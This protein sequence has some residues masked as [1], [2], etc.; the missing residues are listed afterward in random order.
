MAEKISAIT[1][2]SQEH[3]VH[4]VN[5]H[6]ICVAEKMS[7][8]S[9]RRTSRVEDIAYCLMGIFDINMSLLYGEGRKAF[10]RLQQEIVRVFYDM[11]IFAWDQP[12]NRTGSV[13]AS[14]PAGFSASGGIRLVREGAMITSLAQK[15]HNDLLTS[16]ATTNKGLQIDADVWKRSWAYS[17]ADCPMLSDDKW[18]WL[19]SC[20]KFQTAENGGPENCLCAVPLHRNFWATKGRLWVRAEEKLVFLYANAVLRNYRNLQRE[21][22]YINIWGKEKLASPG[23][24]HL[25]HTTVLY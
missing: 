12:D 25:K 1:G 23:L 8:A 5:L 6:S 21:T 11:S 3:L 7:W 10:L 13:F 4:G 14:S 17:E 18:L 22:I 16:Y 9:N 2:I 20:G 19:L 15:L 24:C